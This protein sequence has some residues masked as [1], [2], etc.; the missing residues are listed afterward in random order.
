MHPR[1]PGASHCFGGIVRSLSVCYAAPTAMLML[2]IRLT[3]IWL[4]LLLSFFLFLLL[5]QRRSLRIDFSL[6]WMLS[7]VL[8]GVIFIAVGEVSSSLERLTR[9]FVLASWIVADLTLIGA[10][11]WLARL[12]GEPVYALLLKLARQCWIRFKAQNFVVQSLLIAS[13]TFSLL[14]GIFAVNTPTSIWDCETYHMPRIMHWMQQRSL[15]H[16]P[17]NIPRQ[18]ELAP[19]AEIAMAQLMLLAGDDTPVSLVEWWSLLTASIAAAFL[20]RELL[21]SAH[22]TKPPAELCAADLCF[23]FVLLLA[24]TLPEAACE[25]ITPQNNVVAAMW[26]AVAGA[27]G[28]VFL[29]DRSN[30][31]GL[32]GSAAS[33]GLGVSSKTTEVLYV[34]PFVALGLAFLTWQRVW[35]PALQW[36]I[37]TL[38]LMLTLN[39][40]WMERNEQLFG[41]PLGDKSLFAALKIAHNSPKKVAVNVLRNLSLY[42]RS[43][44]EIATTLANFSIDSVVRFSGESMGDTNAVF[45]SSSVLENKKAVIK[46]GE[47]F[48]NC[49]T[50]LLFILAVS[51]YPFRFKIF[52]PLGAYLAAAV[53]AF[54]LFCGYL[55]YQPWHPRLHIACFLMITPFIGAVL[56]WW[57]DRWVVLLV[58]SFLLA[59]ALLIVLFNPN[60][61]AVPALWQSHSREDLYFV[62]RDN[63]RGPT[64]AAVNDLVRSGCTNVLLKVSNDS[65]EYP[66]WVLLKDRGFRGT[67]HHIAVENASAALPVA[68]FGLFHTA[69]LNDVKAGAIALL[70][71]QSTNYG[72]WTVSYAQS[73]STFR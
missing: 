18:L 36:G 42:T 31:A 69:L 8:V 70:F 34:A 58:G 3:P 7:T 22:K 67:I 65:W 26:T 21:A 43:P 72:P 55:R 45:R 14:L 52:S 6:A 15:S 23:A 1:S 39:G 59:N 9:V 20:S 27:L 68:P 46:R 19:G 41:N 32:I 47:G 44:S 48:G 71:P 56:C 53:A 16:Y 4:C 61:P 33:L 11:W 13:L 29:Q 5:A 66:F 24:M 49:Y 10:L 12:A 63:L 2:F 50:L 17:T 64:I 38:F 54:I 73:K 40:P 62:A 35:M 51:V 37:A 25:S 60:V 57:F 30:M 28:I